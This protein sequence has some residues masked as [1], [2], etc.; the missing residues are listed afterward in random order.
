MTGRKFIA[1]FNGS[2]AGESEIASDKKPRPSTTTAPFWLDGVLC[3][4]TRRG[5]RSGRLACPGRSLIR[6]FANS[7]IRRPA[8]FDYDRA[9]LAGRCVVRQDS[10]RS[11]LRGCESN[12][13]TAYPLVVCRSGGPMPHWAA[14]ESRTCSGAPHSVAQNR[15]N[16]LGTPHDAA[17]S[18]ELPGREAAQGLIHNLSGR[19]PLSPRL[20]V[21]ASP[22]LRV[23]ASPRHQGVTPIGQRAKRM[24]RSFIIPSAL[25]VPLATSL[26]D[27]AKLNHRSLT[28]GSLDSRFR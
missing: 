7:L 10:A 25:I 1:S 8:P 4:K 17:F 26:D 6:Q 11:P 15:P 21:S 20:R 28:R 18:G 5:L 12:P 23:T 9:F 22:C 19:L 3:A 14:A 24:R 27:W 13:F 16:K 2:D